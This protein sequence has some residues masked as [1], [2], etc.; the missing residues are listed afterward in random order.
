MRNTQYRFFVAAF[1]IAVPSVVHNSVAEPLYQAPGK[2]HSRWVSFENP[3]GE[4]GMGGRANQGAKGAAFQTIKAGEQKVLMDVNGGG[5]IRRMWCTLSQ[6]APADLRAYVLRMYWDKAEKPAVEVPLGDFFGAIHGEINP[7]ENIFFSSPEGRSFNFT[8][9][10]PFQSAARITLTNESDK[11]LDQFFYDIN[12]TLEEHPEPPLF[13]HATWRRERYTELKQDFEILPRVTGRGRFLGA[14]I[15]VI[16]HPDNIGWWGEGEVKL[17]LD[18]DTAFPTLV[19]TGTEDYVGTGYL[20]GEYAHRFQGSLLIDNVNQYYGFY[21][22]HVP[23]PIY[24]HRDIRV[25]LQQIGGAMQEFVKEMLANQVEILPISVG[26]ENHYVNLLES[27]PPKTLDDPD[28]PYGWTNYYRRDDVCAVAFFYL[29]SPENPLPPIA[30]LEAR[31][32]A[33]GERRSAH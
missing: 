21:R 22:Y 26:A 23:D 15:G 2:V 20:Q 29:D 24:F 17:Y 14:H 7:F 4:P 8:V 10:M 19:G 3:T 5:V 18:G 1:L 13:F 31:I 11:D 27:D 12:Y 25:T 6:R 28:I 30:P 33:I 32:E 9:E 16:G